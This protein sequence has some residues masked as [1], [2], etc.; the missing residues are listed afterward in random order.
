MSEM[1]PERQELLRQVM[2]VQERSLYGASLI[3]RGL[4]QSKDPEVSSVCL[5]AHAAL[6]N[7]QAVLE[8]MVEKLTATTH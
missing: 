7:T 4:S 5:I 8:A 2:D 6:L 3:F 1:S